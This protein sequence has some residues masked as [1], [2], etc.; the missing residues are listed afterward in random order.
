MRECLFSW[1]IKTYLCALI[2]WERQKKTEKDR[3]RQK[4][5]EKDRK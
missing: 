1:D 4:K 3:K 5:T 2:F